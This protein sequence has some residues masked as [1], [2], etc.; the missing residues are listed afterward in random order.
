MLGLLRQ[1]LG[2]GAVSFA[3]TQQGSTLS[4]R[5]DLPVLA[6]A[7]GEF[8]A[9][10]LAEPGMAWLVRPD[11]YIDWCSATP[12]IEGLQAFLETIIKN[13]SIEA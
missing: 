7:E 10:C 3:I 6:D 11:G 13:A 1:L 2:E 4:A 9:A 12:S 5:D 8:A